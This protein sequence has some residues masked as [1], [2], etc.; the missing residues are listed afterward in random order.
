LIERQ[1]CVVK[2]LENPH[3]NG[4]LLGLEIA[5]HCLTLRKE[6]F[7]CCVGRGF[8]ESTS[9]AIKAQ[10]CFRCTLQQRIKMTEDILRQFYKSWGTQFHA[11]HQLSANH[12]AK[13]LRHVSDTLKGLRPQGTILQGRKGQPS[14][15]W[16]MALACSWRFGI[17]VHIVRPQK[18]MQ[19]LLP[20]VHKTHGIFAIFIE[21]ADKLWEE[22][23][24]EIVRY[25]VSFAYNS[26]ALFWL[27]VC[28]DQAPIITDPQDRTV[29]AKLQQRLHQA[30]SK[31]PMDLL[32][33]K[34]AARLQSLCSLPR[35]SFDEELET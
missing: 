11:P 21:Q 14:E 1:G 25:L 24:A 2:A 30:K 32:G 18:S 4:I 17:P 9:T 6:M 8:Y 19:D 12:S 29:A 31:S 22:Q 23:N 7:P 28:P 34:C 20:P 5:E 26:N 33:A 27:E 15:I 3:L 35:T 16:P 13:L 10:S